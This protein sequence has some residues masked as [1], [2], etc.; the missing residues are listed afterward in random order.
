[1]SGK[2]LKRRATTSRMR[3]RIEHRSGTLDAGSGV[4]R[5]R[6]AAR[7]ARQA[8]PSRHRETL[9]GASSADAQIVI[10]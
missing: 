1:M 7:G 5:L 9:Y 4:A 10:A 6:R 8:A 3:L 2:R